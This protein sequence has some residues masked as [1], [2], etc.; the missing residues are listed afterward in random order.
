MELMWTS[1]QRNGTELKR[2]KSPKAK[3]KHAWRAASLG[4]SFP[5]TFSKDQT[6]GARNEQRHEENTLKPTENV[7]PHDISRWMSW[8]KTPFIPARP[9]SCH[10]TF[11][12]ALSRTPRHSEADFYIYA[13]RLRFWGSFYAVS[14]PILCPRYLSRFSFTAVNGVK[15]NFFLV[16]RLSFTARRAEQL[17]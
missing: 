7:V 1:M 5:T 3:R 4:M 2:Q 15:I 13:F 16:L 11:P 8:G 17:I 6:R 10:T 14:S 12:K 9:K